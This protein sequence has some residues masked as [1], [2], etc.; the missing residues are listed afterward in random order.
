MENSK[1]STWL[2]LVEE[3]NPQNIKLVIGLTWFDRVLWCDIEKSAFINHKDTPTYYKG[4][5]NVLEAS[6]AKQK[7]EYFLSTYL[8]K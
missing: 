6:A 8:I 2:V 7:W 4:F 3:S 1:K 5:N